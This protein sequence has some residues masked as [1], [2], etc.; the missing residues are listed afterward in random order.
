MGLPPGQGGPGYVRLDQS[1]VMYG[2]PR[3][4][5]ADRAG[6]T[7]GHSSLTMDQSPRHQHGF[8]ADHKSPRDPWPHHHG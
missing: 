1:S 7:R 8:K 4:G 2:Y 5:E 6:V 3:G